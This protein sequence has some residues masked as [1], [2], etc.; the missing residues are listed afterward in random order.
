MF[1]TQKSNSEFQINNLREQVGNT[2]LRMIEM[3]SELKRQTT[4]NRHVRSGFGSYYICFG[5]TTSNPE[6]SVVDAVQLILDH[7]GL[8]I[9]ENEKLSLVEKQ[10]KSND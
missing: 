3:E 8:E 7:L 9:T 5:D 1:K 4:V 6:V 10:E 2:N